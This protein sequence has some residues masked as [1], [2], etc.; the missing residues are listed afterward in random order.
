MWET[1]SKGSCGGDVDAWSQPL[2]AGSASHAMGRL[3]WPLI[4]E[5]GMAA[6]DVPKEPTEYF[7]GEI[8]SDFSQVGGASKSPRCSY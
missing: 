7:H 5:S 1:R 8:F 4:I 2:G 6:P 3:V